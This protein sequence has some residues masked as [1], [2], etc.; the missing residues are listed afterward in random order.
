MPLPP[1]DRVAF[2]ERFVPFMLILSAAPFQPSGYESL[3]TTVIFLGTIEEEDETE[4]DEL[5]TEELLPGTE[6]EL[7]TMM[8]DELGVELLLEPLLAETVN[9]PSNVQVETFTPFL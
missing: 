4:L 8:L 6:L 5:G 7:L 3:I 2:G 9:E 1:E